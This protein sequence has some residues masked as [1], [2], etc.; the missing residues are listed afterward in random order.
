MAFGFK[1]LFDSAKQRVLLGAGAAPAPIDALFPATDP[2]VDG[3][4]CAHDC[5]TCTIHYPRAF[6]ID[7]TDRLYGFVKGWNSHVLVATG[8][9]DWV[10]D[11]TDERGSVM[12]ALKHAEPGN[13][14]LMLSA[15][16][17]PIGPHEPPSYATPTRVLLL[18]AIYA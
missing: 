6:K 15:S 12:E 10:R 17:L 3:D 11:V 1:A 14:R 13:G 16:N 8:K 5:A 4:A 18:P 9:S 7:T 2:A